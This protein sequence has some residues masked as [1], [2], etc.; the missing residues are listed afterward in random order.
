[1]SNQYIEQTKRW[2]EQ[3]VLDL[4]LCPFA[5]AAYARERIYYASN[6]FAQPMEIWEA[7]TAQIDLLELEP[8][9]DSTFLIWENSEVDFETYLA[10]TERLEDGLVLTNWNHKYQIVSFHPSY[11]F[12]DSTPLDPADYTN[13]SPYPMWQLIKA[14]MIDAGLEQGM[15]L[16]SIPERNKAKCAAL[17]IS[18]F[19]QLMDHIKS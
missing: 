3:V 12:A 2:I 15:D 14:E 11:R 1:M 9:W 18:Y 19:V 8:Q 13:R 4:D 7:L 6:A 17:G 10:I 16:A 5:Y